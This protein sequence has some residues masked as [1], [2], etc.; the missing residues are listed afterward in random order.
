MTGFYDYRG[1][2]SCFITEH[3]LASR[4]IN[5]SERTM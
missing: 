1:E 4:T 3:F 2:M 5:C